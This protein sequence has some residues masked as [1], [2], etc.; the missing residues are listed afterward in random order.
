MFSWDGLTVRAIRLYHN[1]SREEFAERCHVS[2]G[3]IGA[4]ESGHRRVTQ[5]MQ[6]K[7]IK[8]FELTDDIMHLINRYKTINGL[9]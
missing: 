6:L 7:I 1:L 8:A 2:L 3:T 4:L 9:E 5:N